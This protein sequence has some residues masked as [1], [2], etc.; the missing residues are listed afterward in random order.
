M[1]VRTLLPPFGFEVGEERADQRRV[2]VVDVQLERLF[3]G[4]LMREVQQQ[5]ECVAV[6]GDRAWA[7]VTLGDQP[8]GE[9]RLQRGRDRAHDD[10]PGSRSSR[11]PTSCSSSGTACR[12]Q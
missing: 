12:Y 7:G 5:P 3:T 9:E 6:G 4:L 10:T 1:R 11:S 8:V 2:E